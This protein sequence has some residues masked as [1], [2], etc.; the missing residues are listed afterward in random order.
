MD[1]ASIRPGEIVGCAPDRADATLIFIGRVRTP[2]RS[3]R[4]C[5]RHGH[6]D[7]PICRIEIDE[8]WRQ[9]MQ[10][11][12]AHSELQVLYWMDK[13]RRDLLVQRPRTGI[14]PT[15]TF[16]LRSPMRPNPI[17]V[18]IVAVA[19]IE[20]ST[21]LVRGLDCLDGTPIVDIKPRWAG[22]AQ[23]NR[24]ASMAGSSLSEIA[25]EIA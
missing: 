20:D 21:I 8:P 11:L 7:G 6:T 4:D 15:G 16:A 14:G 22:P 5:P 13:A 19:A 12:E 1:K 18:S 3:L 9:A 24:W 10:G 2:Y 23:P 17:A 25:R